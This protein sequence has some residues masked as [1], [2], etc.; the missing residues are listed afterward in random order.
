MEGGEVSHKCQEEN[1]NTIR[2]SVEGE[3]LS[4][5]RRNIGDLDWI[6]R[7][8]LSPRE[9]YHDKVMERENGDKVPWD[10]A[11]DCYDSVSLLFSFPDCSFLSIDYLER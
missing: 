10:C 1:S 4:T 11:D 5:K 8:W 9:T 3:L 7:S 2:R 6:S